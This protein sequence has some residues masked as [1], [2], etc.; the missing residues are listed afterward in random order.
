MCPKKSKIFYQYKLPILH[1][2][3]NK[4]NFERKYCDFYIFLLI[5]ANLEQIVDVTWFEFVTVFL[6]DLWSDLYK[7]FNKILISNILCGQTKNRNFLR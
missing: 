7:Y 5:I 6:Y 1:N 2:A 4:F 3:L